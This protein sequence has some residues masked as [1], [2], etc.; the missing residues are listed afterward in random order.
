MKV[1]FSRYPGGRRRA[2]TLSYDDGQIFDRRLVGIMNENGIR[3][4]FHLNSGKFDSPKFVTAAEIAS[5][6]AGHEVSSHSLTHPYLDRIPDAEL[7]YEITEDRLR[8]E[9]ACGYVVRGMSY[10]YGAW[11]P[12]LINRLA[13]LGIHYSRT[14]ESTNNFALPR[15]FMRWGATCHHNGNIAERLDAFRKSKNPLAL[16]YIW[17][18]SYEFDRDGNWELIENFCRAAG[19]DP[20]IW[21]AT[22]IEIYDYLT[23]LRALDL[24]A[25]RTAAYN[26]SGIPVWLDV[27]GEAIEI[28][29]RRTV[30]FV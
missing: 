14:T 4:T 26:P 23:A 1:H 3:G 27:D 11:T 17:G 29:A 15:D 2:L 10:P 12:E 9:N 20:D 28:P 19:G 30:K 21:Y 16:F 6:Y 7:N 13:A 18:H 25:D 24:S 5:L 8:L 22:N